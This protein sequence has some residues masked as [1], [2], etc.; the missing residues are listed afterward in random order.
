MAQT[1]AEWEAAWREDAGA[2][3]SP[4]RTVLFPVSWAFPCFRAIY[5][6]LRSV[7]ALL[8]QPKFLQSREIAPRTARVRI[9]ISREFSAHQQGSQ[10][11]ITG[12][13]LLDFAFGPRLISRCHC[14]RDVHLEA[15]ADTFFPQAPGLV[16]G[17]SKSVIRATVY[18]CGLCAHV[19][20]RPVMSHR[21]SARQQG[22]VREPIATSSGGGGAPDII[23]RSVWGRHPSFSSFCGTPRPICELT[24]NRRN[25]RTHPK[26]QLRQ[27]AG[28]IERFGF[29]NLSVVRTFGTT[30]GVD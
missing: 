19:Q 8:A 12:N 10:I 3:R 17:A 28:S 1:P 5:R 13:C 29:S 14:L 20:R 9:K 24:P 6:G 11:T 15:R 25:A 23:K 30:R 27:L 2:R 18:W 26:K 4:E 16:S 21:K 22:L 7:L